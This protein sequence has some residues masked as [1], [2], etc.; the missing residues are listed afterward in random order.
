MDELRKD[1]MMSSLLDALERGEDIGH[2]GRLVVVM[3]G[4]HF[5]ER[6]AL[7]ALISG[8]SCD[9]SS[10]RMMV[11]QVDEADY[12]PP[13][14]AKIVAYG[15]KQDYVIIA[16]DA[17]PDYGNVYRTLEFP[18]HVYEHIGEYREAKTAAAT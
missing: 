5:L 17:D 3:I 18:E 8:G 1:P 2:Y 14:R 10:A 13:R 12:S 9:D 15:A 7:V 6:D 4:R 16:E 11:Q